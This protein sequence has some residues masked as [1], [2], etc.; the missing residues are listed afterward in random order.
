MAPRLHEGRQKSTRWFKKRAPSFTE[1]DPVRRHLA[2]SAS[3]PPGAS[4]SQH[5]K[6]P[7][8]PITPEPCE[9]VTTVNTSGSH[10]PP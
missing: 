9:Q 2:R 6:R 5:Q 7:D 10:G 4:P 8:N 1:G 3:D